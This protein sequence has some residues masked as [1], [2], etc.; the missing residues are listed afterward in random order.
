[1]TPCAFHCPIGARGELMNNII[2]DDIG[3]EK[4]EKRP[5]TKDFQSNYTNNQWYCFQ[6][7]QTVFFSAFSSEQPDKASL[8]KMATSLTRLAP[9][10]A[11]GYNGAIAGEPLSE[12]VLAQLINIEMIDELDDYPQ[13][14]DLSGNDI[15]SN[16]NLPFFRIKAVVRKNGIDDLGRA[17]MIMIL[18]THALI[19]GADASLLSRSRKAKKDSIIDKPKPISKIKSLG[20]GAMAAILA[21][22]QLL[23][24]Q[25]LVP[26]KVDANYKALNIGREK[27][28]RIS[29]KLD[30]SQR[31]LI[32]ALA[33]YVLND[34]GKGFSKKTISAIYAD[35]NDNG[36]FQTN[37]DFFRFR[38]VNIKFKVDEDFI[39][40]AKNVDRAIIAAENSDIAKTQALLNAMFAMHRRLKKILPF[41]YL[42]RVFRFSA[43][44]H[45]SLSLLPPQRLFGRITKGMMEPIYAGTFHPGM[46][47]CVFAPGRTQIT[48]NFSL[49][50][51]HLKSVDNLSSLLDK[52]EQK[53][54]A[55]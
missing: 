3:I 17:S 45:L 54:S 8:M 12:D 4:P 21:P 34:G 33:T 31:A 6:A 30:I 5:T 41:L 27:I 16:H 18:S 55:N 53:R 35:L 42:G 50:K 10:L 44:Y 40:Y 23:G 47:M 20:Y 38:M 36:Q 39:T 46:N 25:L 43:N 37:D 29:E 15:F 22:L 52:I 24:A 13:K 1:M 28:K 2:A 9:Q 7:K 26:K 51:R 32:F 11:S 19:E 48:F 49:Q 14:W